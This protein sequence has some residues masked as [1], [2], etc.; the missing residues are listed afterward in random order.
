M[1]RYRFLGQYRRELLGVRRFHKVLRETFGARFID[2][3]CED[4]IICFR[5][6]LFWPV[7]VDCLPSEGEEEREAR[8]ENTGRFGQYMVQDLVEVLYC[9]FLCRMA[10]QRGV[11]FGLS[12]VLKDESELVGHRFWLCFVLPHTFDSSYNELY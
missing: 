8:G 10:K 3:S 4:R 6:Q 12:S 9:A 11:H 2:K 7:E 5:A 1:K